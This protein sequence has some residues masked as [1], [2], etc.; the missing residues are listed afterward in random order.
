MH[1]LKKIPK[2]SIKLWK[3]KN[4]HYCIKIVHKTII[5]ITN[6]VEDY[7]KIIMINK[8][9]LQAQKILSYVIVINNNG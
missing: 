9:N 5:I 2:F 3:R 1:I 8:T 7:L 6:N 4:N